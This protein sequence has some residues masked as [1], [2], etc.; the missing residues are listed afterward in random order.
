MERDICSYSQVFAIFVVRN[1]YC[2]LKEKTRICLP[3]R[4]SLPIAHCSCAILKKACLNPKHLFSKQS[5]LP[6]SNPP[7]DAARPYD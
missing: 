1:Q 5:T 3:Q 7:R 6:M 4:T 2:F